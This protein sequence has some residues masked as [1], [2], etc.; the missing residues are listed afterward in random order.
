[1]LLLNGYFNF[2]ACVLLCRCSE[3]KGVGRC[4]FVGCTRVGNIKLQFVVCRK[5]LGTGL[6]LNL[7]ILVYSLVVY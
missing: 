1:M 7:V 3:K 6:A 4:Q 5:F 2:T